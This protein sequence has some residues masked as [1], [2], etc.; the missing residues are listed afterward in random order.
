MNIYRYEW[1]PVSPA[2][3]GLFALPTHLLAMYRAVSS[4]YTG[5]SQAGNM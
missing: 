2:A 1:C 4:G 5:S 3:V